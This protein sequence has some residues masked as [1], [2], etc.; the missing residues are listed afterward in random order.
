MKI[1]ALITFLMITSI[2]NMA[3]SHSCTSHSSGDC[4]TTHYD[5]EQTQSS[6]L[7]LGVD[8]L[9]DKNFYVVYSGMDYNGVLDNTSNIYVIKGVNDSVWIFGTGYADKNGTT[10]Y[11]KNKGGPVKYECTRNAIDD[12]K[13]A[14]S[15]IRYAFQLSPALVKLQFIVPHEHHDHMN[16][17][18]LTAM[19]DSL[20]YN[21]NYSTIFAH[22][23]DS[24]GVVCNEEPCC[25]AGTCI[26]PWAVLIN[27]LGT[28]NDTCNIPL[29][30]FSTAFGSWTVR[31]ADILHTPGS[32]NIDNVNYNVRIV[33]AAGNQCANNYGLTSLG[34][35]GNLKNFSTVYL[36]TNE[37]S[38]KNIV[39]NAY[40]NPVINTLV[41][42]LNN[43]NDNEEKKEL[44]ITNSLG[45][46]VLNTKLENKKNSIDVS[47]LSAG[48]YFINAVYNNTTASAPLKIIITH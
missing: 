5:S 13:Q 12:A 23:N 48:I 8:N 42:E 44:I 33:G 2:N 32:I 10:A 40:P 27:G 4:C 21:S 45:Q 11:L 35:H 34:I 19:F 7:H 41:I 3:T 14:D 38:T 39:F 15:I 6:T 25:S 30:N 26:N 36:S 1:S 22:V 16:R 24:A 28:A 37:L 31:K 46:T 9:V 29:M 47:T 43:L 20:G 18:F 17:E